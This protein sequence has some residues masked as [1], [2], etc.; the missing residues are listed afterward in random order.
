MN[1]ERGG[2]GRGRNPGGGRFGGRGH[3]TRGLT[4]SIGAYLDYA[5]GR[6]ANISYT[7]LWSKKVSE[8]VNTICDTKVATIFG[9]NGTIGPYF[10]YAKPKAPRI[11][12]A[13]N[14]VVARTKLKIWELAY[15][16]YNK[17]I[18]K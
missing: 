11:D 3:I 15:A 7:T 18:V 9:P 8:Y 6:E 17:T 1:Y 14:S 5:P 16:E 13:D 10:K 2:R 4:P 12:E